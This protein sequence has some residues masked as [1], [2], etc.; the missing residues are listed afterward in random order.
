MFVSSG[1]PPSHTKRFVSVH[2]QQHPVLFK[3]RRGIEIIFRPRSWLAF[4][5]RVYYITPHIEASELSRF[6]PEVAAWH[7]RA[8]QVPSFPGSQGRRCSDPL[9][10]CDS[11]V[12]VSDDLVQSC[13]LLVVAPRGCLHD[14]SL[15]NWPSVRSVYL[16]LT[17][18]S[19]STPRW[20]THSPIYACHAT[21]E[22]V[23]GR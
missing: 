19:D 8:Y 23:G 2:L 5:P 12:Q 3:R 1:R 17:L 15:P 4:G 22:D 18:C 10:R 21:P 7:A 9:N 6:A 11:L 20:T 16:Y 14:C 13:R